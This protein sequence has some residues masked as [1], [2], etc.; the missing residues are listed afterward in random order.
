MVIKLFWSLEVSLGL[1]L[2]HCLLFSVVLLFLSSSLQKGK[3]IVVCVLSI[4]FASISRVFF[5][6]I[7]VFASSEKIMFVKGL[8][9]LV[10]IIISSSPQEVI[11]IIYIVINFLWLLGMTFELS[12]DSSCCG[13]HCFL[14]LIVSKAVIRILNVILASVS[15]PNCLLFASAHT[16]LASFTA[17]TMACLWSLATFY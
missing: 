17:S 4:L 3:G 5:F 9:K 15:K 13:S 12:V 8:A 1:L 6:I 10:S 11:E 14:K 16:T 2:Q 7:I